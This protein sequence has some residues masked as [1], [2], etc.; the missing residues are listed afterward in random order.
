MTTTDFLRGMLIISTLYM[1]LIA[2]TL[3]EGPFSAGASGHL[4]QSLGF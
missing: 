1:T 3:V 2:V 4:I